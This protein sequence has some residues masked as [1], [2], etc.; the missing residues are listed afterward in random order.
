MSTDLQ[1]KSIV[2]AKPFNLV[3]LVLVGLVETHSFQ[4]H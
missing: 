3:S 4:C 1:I 2:Q